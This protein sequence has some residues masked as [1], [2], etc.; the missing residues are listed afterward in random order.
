MEVFEKAGL[1]SRILR[2][3]KKFEGWTYLEQGLA[4]ERRGLANKRA[5][6]SKE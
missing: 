2:V 5:R 4:R 6:K 1:G 3:P